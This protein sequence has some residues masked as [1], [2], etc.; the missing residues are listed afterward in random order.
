[1][2]VQDGR[3][4][5]KLYLESTFTFR[6][7]LNHSLSIKP[8]PLSSLYYSARKIIK[9]R[10]HQ[11]CP[12][13]ARSHNRTCTSL[14]SCLLTNSLAFIFAHL[15]WRFHGQLQ[16]SGSQER[17]T[18]QTE[19][20]SDLLSTVPSRSSGGGRRSRRSSARGTCGSCSS[21]SCGSLSGCL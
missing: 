17:S 4:L 1:M 3:T 7:F 9:H 2:V 15:L 21:G 5:S 16:S 12:R 11:V 19:A 14:S 20:H 6:A 18:H 8:I 13:W 10:K